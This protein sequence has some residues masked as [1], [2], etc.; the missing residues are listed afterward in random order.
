MLSPGEENISN[1]R[2]RQS[3]FYDG[4]YLNIEIL[5][6]FIIS[7][8]YRVLSTQGVFCQMNS[9]ISVGT[10]SKSTNGKDDAVLMA[11]QWNSA[12]AKYKTLMNSIPSETTVL[13]WVLNVQ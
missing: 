6:I 1:F 4:K 12:I 8:R 3:V 10:R 11:S 2:G 9:N 7:P 5:E 13:T